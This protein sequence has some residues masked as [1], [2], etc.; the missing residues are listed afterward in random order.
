MVV[1]FYRYI[2]YFNQDLHMI[3][4]Y[5]LNYLI[6][7]LR[8]FIK[9]FLNLRRYNLVR[10]LLNLFLGML[11]IRLNLFE[12]RLFAHLMHILRCGILN[13]L[14]LCPRYRESLLYA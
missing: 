4:Q 9:R 3:Q 2:R 14:C 12:I 13:C 1:F 5:N 8:L 10:I 11:K 7:I 6:D